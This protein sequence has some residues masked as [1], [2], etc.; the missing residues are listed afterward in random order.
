M[1]AAVSVECDDPVRFAKENVRKD[2]L[3]VTIYLQTSLPNQYQEITLCFSMR[4]GSWR[5]EF[6][7]T[8]HM[9]GT[10]NLTKVP[11][12]QRLTTSDL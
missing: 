8:G 3:R 2:I 1:L 9:E 12:E 4:G 5:V 7:V 6:S 11:C 10:V